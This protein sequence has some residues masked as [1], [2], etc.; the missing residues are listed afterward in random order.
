MDEINEQVAQRLRS[1]RQSTGMSLNDL[2]V[3]SGVSRATLSQIETLKVN[4]TIAVL[5]K[6]AAGLGVPFAELI[7]T[8]LAPAV[9]VS[10]LVDAR[11]L[12]SADRRFQSR[13]LLA[14]VPGHNVELYELELGSGAEEHAEPHPVGTYE[15][16]VVMSGRLALVLGAESYELGERDAVLFRADVAHTYRA[17]GPQSFRGLSLILYGG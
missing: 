2:A 7:G 13:P 9:R 17:V 3:R 15:Q 16:L 12:F 5:W 10:R 4:P 1:L 6:I 8:P 14:R 11:F